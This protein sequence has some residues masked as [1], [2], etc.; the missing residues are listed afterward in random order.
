MHGGSVKESIVDLF[1][2]ATE[3]MRFKI[4]CPKLYSGYCGVS[5]RILSYKW[6]VICGIPDVI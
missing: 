1:N 6:L 3:N 5:H 2:G 4:S